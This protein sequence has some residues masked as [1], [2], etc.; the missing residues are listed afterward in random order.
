M[1]AVTDNWPEMFRMSLAA[2][3]L[4]VKF[5]LHLKGPVCTA[6]ERSSKRV[7]AAPKLA[8]TDIHLSTGTLLTDPLILAETVPNS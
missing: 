4:V 1:E 7:S 3:V 8:H 6:P 5:L 2:T